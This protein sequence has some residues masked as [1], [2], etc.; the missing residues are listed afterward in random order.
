MAAPA[1]Q[2]AA[3][4]ATE[5]T[6]LQA[7]A[8]MRKKAVTHDTYCDELLERYREVKFFRALQLSEHEGAHPEVLSV[9]HRDIS[10]AASQAAAEAAAAA[11]AKAQEL[12][13]PVKTPIAPAVQP[14]PEERF[15]YLRSLL[16][17]VPFVV[18]NNIDA[19][20]HQTTAGSSALVG[21]SRPSRNAA[22]VEGMRAAGA[23]VMGS[24]STHSLS[25]GATGTLSLLGPVV[26]PYTDL[27]IAG[28]S[29][30]GVAAAVSARFVPFGLA[31]DTVGDARAP[32]ALCGVVAFRPTLGRYATRGLLG[33]ASTLD[34]PSIVAR[35]VKD[36]RF[37][38]TLL[39]ATREID[40]PQYD[41]PVLKRVPVEGEEEEEEEEEGAPATDEEELE[42]AAARIQALLRGKA[43]RSRVAG[44]RAAAQP[45][46]VA[47]PEQEQAALRIQ[48]IARGRIGRKAV[49]DMVSERESAA[50][51]RIQALLRGRATRAS[52]SAPAPPA[53][54]GASEG[55]EGKEE[56][57]P[58]ASLPLAGKRI[59]VPWDALWEAAD[60][61]VRAAAEEAISAL[62]AAG[63]TIVR[64]P[65]PEVMDAA[66]LAGT[67]AAPP[68]PSAPRAGQRK[69]PHGAPARA[70]GGRRLKRGRLVPLADAAWN[71]A[72]II[73]QFETP[74][75]LSMYLSRSGLDARGMT[76]EGVV[77]GALASDVEKEGVLAQLDPA[78]ALDPETYRLALLGTREAVGTALRDYF[79]QHAL[80]ALLHPTTGVPA[81]MAR[82]AEDSLVLCNGQLVA[83]SK[84]LLGT[85]CIAALMGA[86]AIT[87]PVG[88]VK[89]RPDVKPGNPGSER[90]PVG[91]QLM[92]LP[93]Q[94]EA[95]LGV[96]LQLQAHLTPLVDPIVLR[97]WK[98]GVHKPS[99]RLE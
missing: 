7:L 50:A 71:A 5:L 69:A 38:D 33:T 47:D 88:T 66:A 85:T 10:G 79:A 46:A 80:T 22:I 4:Q 18:S 65:L 90:V 58:D 44:M 25:L 73:R 16:G 75:E 19:A 81:S 61:T 72:D 12:G 15:D 48:A 45:A 76:V 59:G 62:Q 40:C 31:V 57:G 94:D 23:W 83:A 30:S 89:P 93:G 24:A 17:G 86:P 27:G 92:A 32:A 98:L 20:L 35:C 42:A 37:L 52:L 3:L 99:K 26:N 43:A 64:A 8:A 56:A 29:A 87:L 67:A 68:P 74:R 95:L 97:R 96:A 78:S 41:L 13:M 70:A 21:L 11:A 63:A 9:S 53:G 39:T 36:V 91:V 6:L 1:A 34:A 60:A 2:A 82:G 28:G 84:A 49:A 51:S 14:A 77:A 55:K 54:A